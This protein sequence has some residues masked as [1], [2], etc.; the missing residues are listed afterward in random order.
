MGV[1]MGAVTDL[2]ALVVVRVL[3][4]EHRHY[5]PRSTCRRPIRLRIRAG[6]WSPC[7][8]DALPLTTPRD[9][10]DDDG[11]VKEGD[12]LVAPAAAVVGPRRRRD[13][14]LGSV[15]VVAAIV[16]PATADAAPKLRP[17]DAYSSLVG[18]RNEL[19]YAADTYLSGGDW[20]DMRVY[21]ETK[22]V[23]MNNY[24]TIAGALLESKRLDAESKRDIGTIRRYGVGADVI[25]M[26]GGLRKELFVVSDDAI[27]D[28][29]GWGDGVGRDGINEAEVRSEE[30]PSSDHGKS[31]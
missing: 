29:E 6:G 11:I 2:I 16:P 12:G 15:V 27:G 19:R 14:L 18:E 25:I 1:A 26:Y 13:F 21:L 5:P 30:V 28:D 3:V 20:D 7:G 8:Y 10:D 31:R 24:E 9:D 23:N 4:N 17:D 22:A